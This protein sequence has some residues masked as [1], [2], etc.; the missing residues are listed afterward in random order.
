MG[1]LLF[2]PVSLPGISVTK[3]AE[4]VQTQDRIIRSFP[5]VESVFGKA[6]RAATATDPAPTGAAMPEFAW[7][8]TDNDVAAVLTYIRNSWGNAAPAVNAAQVGTARHELQE[9][10]D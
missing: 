2:M 5:E 1:T 9:R 6:G 4:L 8:L 7:L 3:A 10:S